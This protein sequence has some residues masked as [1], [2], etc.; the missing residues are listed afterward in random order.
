MQRIVNYGSFLQAYGLKKIIESLGHEVVFIDYHVESPISRIGSVQSSNKY[1]ELLKQIIKPR[2]WKMRK[3]YRDNNFIERYESEFLSILGITKE[4]NYNSKVDTMLIGSDEVFN[5]L[6]NNPL[7]GY[8][9]ELFGKNTKANRV[10][11]YAASFGTTTLNKLENHG[12]LD[13]IR[14][15]LLKMDSISVRDNNSFKIVQKLTK[16]EPF[17]NLDPVLIYKFEKEIE[18]V[19]I[20]EENYILVY[21]YCERL[22]KDEIR[23]IKKFAKKEKLKLLCVGFPQELCDF[24]V[25]C[26]PFEVLAYVK[27]AK[28]II[29]DTFHGTVFSI[30]YNKKFATIIRE[31]NKQ[32]LSDLLMRF[33]CEDR[34]VSK[35]FDIEDIL[36]KDMN[37]KYINSILKREYVKTINYLKENL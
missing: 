20:L 10:I 15:Y 37:F 18:N 25:V 22:S 2:F 17:I 16:K 33:Q 11:S 35:D 31:S 14:K 13:E 29:T 4:P 7:V 1:I 12:K 26:T 21:A 19:N 8:S 24:N 34:I 3:L 23:E 9:L 28:Y 36:N 6:Q 30:K 5:C 27:K 32:K